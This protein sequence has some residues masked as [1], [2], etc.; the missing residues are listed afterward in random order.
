MSESDKL[1]CV[2]CQK[3][4]FCTCTSFIEWYDALEYH[5][6]IIMSQGYMCPDCHYYDPQIILNSITSSRFAEDRKEER[7]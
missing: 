6:W 7:E 5:D 1:V 2:R 3:E 4:F